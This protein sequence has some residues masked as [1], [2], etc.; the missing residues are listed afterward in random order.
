MNPVIDTYDDDSYLDEFDPIID[1]Y[2]PQ[3]VTL[4][5][6][7][8]TIEDIYSRY[9]KYSQSV[10]R[11]QFLK[12]ICSELKFTDHTVAKA[13]EVSRSTARRLR[14]TFTNL[15]II[16]TIKTDGFVAEKYYTWNGPFVTCYKP[17]IQ[18]NSTKPFSKTAQVLRYCHEYRSAKSSQIAEAL[19]LNRKTVQNILL[20]LRDS[21]KLPLD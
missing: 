8:L 6:V 3:R 16:R 14:K 19:S 12:F 17:S 5:P 15:G 21:G 20:R 1:A 4:K 7:R 10:H 18:T 13:L 11:Y 2:I 9:A